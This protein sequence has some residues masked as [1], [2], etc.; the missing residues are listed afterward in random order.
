MMSNGPPHA[1][2]AIGGVGGS[3]TRVGAALLR[4][5]GFYIGQDLNEPLDNLWFTLL[6]K[7]RSILLETE[8]DFRRLVS[9]FWDRMS[10]RVEFADDERALLLRLADDGR[11]QHSAEW[12]AQRARSFLDGAG[13]AAPGQRWGWKEPNTCIVIH[14][15]L[16][17]QPPLRYIHFV[18]HPIDMA[19]SSNQNQLQNWGPVVASRDVEISA[20]ESLTYWCA[21]HRR[22]VSLQERWPDRILCVGFEALCAEPL[23]GFAEIA[24]FVDADQTEGSGADFCALVAQGAPQGRRSATVDLQQFDQRDI[25]HVR[26]FGFE[27]P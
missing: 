17:C 11:L 16:E 27:V 26:Q 12:L 23:K 6:F 20:R 13:S 25:E 10:G 22:I 24:A 2:V 15:L 14:R 19:L 8:V 4:L 21:L 5:L 3:G 18:R 1:V 7:R 9:L